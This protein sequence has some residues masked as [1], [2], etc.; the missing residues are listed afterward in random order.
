MFLTNTTKNRKFIHLTFEL[1]DFVGPEELAKMF[2]D[3]RNHFSLTGEVDIAK[4]NELVE[5][6]IPVA[7]EVASKYAFY[8]GNMAQE[9]VSVALL[10]LVR[11]VNSAIK[12]TAC[13]GHANYIGSIAVSISGRCAR[14]YERRRLVRYPY[15][16]S[17]TRPHD[18]PTIK[19]NSGEVEVFASD[20]KMPMVDTIEELLQDAN[21]T[22]LE[23]RIC[24]LL[25]SGKKLKEVCKILGLSDNTV[26]KYRESAK[27]KVTGVLFR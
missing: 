25:R 11:V 5:L 24:S 20:F 7:V 10:E 6:M 15:S 8:A 26:R 12:G 21:L 1:P 19:I 17:C 14:A 16:I 4:R 22:E 27:R 3:L 23:M 2:A 9:F 13:T 18:I